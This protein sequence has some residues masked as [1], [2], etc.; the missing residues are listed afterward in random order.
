MRGP[1]TR[2]DHV[3]KPFLGGQHQHGY[4]IGEVAVEDATG[5]SCS[6]VN[7]ESPFADPTGTGR[8]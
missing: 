3:G 2:D 1:E 6:E 5:G 4:R 7:P 8:H